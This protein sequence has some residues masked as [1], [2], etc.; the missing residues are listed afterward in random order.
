MEKTILILT[1]SQDD[2][3][4]L[5]IDQLSSKGADL[6]RFNTNEFHSKV[7]A[8]MHLSG[9]GDFQGRYEFPDSVLPF[10]Q[11]GVVWNRR[12]HE[13][14]L[15]YDLGNPEL[16][17]WMADEAE[18]AMNI[19]FTMFTCPVINPWE[20]NERLKFNKMIQMQ[21]AASLGLEVPLSCITNNLSEIK[22]FWREAEEEVIFKKIRKG[23][24]RFSNGETLLLHTSK[25]PREMMTEENL[26]RMR[27][28]PMFLQEHI[29]KRFDVRSVV[30]D[31]KVFSVTIDSQGVEE[32]KTDYRTAAVMGKLKEMP[33]KEIDLGED[34]NKKLVAFSKSFG[35]TFSVIDLV[36]T[37]DGRIVFLED[38]PNGQWA[39]LEHMTGA[40]ISEAFANT[41]IEFSQRSS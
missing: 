6:V 30:V 20:I 34:V 3:A 29:P 7:K 11:V 22:E 27:F 28:S 12:I 8:V 17:A 38:N 2:C 33:H 1:H 23:L 5:V 14:E 10:S 21:R 9:R 24:F 26:A 16:Q 35:L 37:P 13:P 32:G 39:W 36:I 25:I 31:E 41:L 40:P 15:D 19:S 4:K 18:M